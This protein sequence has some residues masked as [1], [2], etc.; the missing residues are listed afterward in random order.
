VSL[1]PFPFNMILLILICILSFFSILSSLAI[2]HYYQKNATEKSQIFNTLLMYGCLAFMNL[3]FPA[4]I[5]FDILVLRNN[6]QISTW[7]ARYGSGWFHQVN[8]FIGTTFILACIGAALQLWFKFIDQNFL[9]FLRPLLVHMNKERMH[10]SIPRIS[11]LLL[12]VTEIIIM[13][14][15]WQDSFRGVIFNLI[16]MCSALLVFGVLQVFLVCTKNKR[17]G[18]V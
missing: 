11:L 14:V 4:T 8:T 18:G 13:A 17:I 2:Y 5:A 15:C 10:H 7:D 16:I 3:S 12:I 9:V 1:I 6:P